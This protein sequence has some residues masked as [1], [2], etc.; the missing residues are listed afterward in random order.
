MKLEELKN[1]RIAILWFWKEG[2]S[3]FIFLLKLGITEITILD[4]NTSCFPDEYISNSEIPLSKIDDFLNCSW[5]IDEHLT[6]IDKRSISI[7]TGEAYIDHLWD[8][9]VIFKTPGISPFDTHIEPYRDRLSSQTDLFFQNYTGKT[10]WVTATKGKSTIS[11]ILYKALQKAGLK[12]KLVGNIWTPVLDE[13]NIIHPDKDDMYDF[14]IYELSSYMLDTLQPSLDIAILGNIYTDHLDWHLNQENY[15]RAKLNLLKNSHHKVINA[16]LRESSDIIKDENTHFFWTQWDYYAKDWDF[17]IWDTKV[18]DESDVKIKWTHNTINITSIIGVFH[19]LWLDI[20]YLTKVTVMF[21]WL[22]HRLEDIWT[23]K[24]ITFIDDAISTIPQ[25]TIAALKTY[26]DSVWVLFLWWTDRGYDFKQLAKYIHDNEI[27]NL[28]FF[29]PSWSRIKEEI[30]CYIDFFDG[31]DSLDNNYNILETSSMAEAVEFA[32]KHWKPWDICLL[33]TASPSYSI[34]KNF[35]AQW[36]EFK[37]EV[38]SQ[39]K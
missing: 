29:P 3:T 27:K 32:Y 37:K 12:V 39:G 33:S 16:N 28:V 35:E 8:F 15:R 24:W 1:K 5:I 20:E 22:P 25:S 31:S 14:I 9:D 26:R 30:H 23:Y 6:D 4:K 2:R 34:W 36:E 19:I 7:I 13:V 21:G 38:I 10:I 17:F 11:T 18:M